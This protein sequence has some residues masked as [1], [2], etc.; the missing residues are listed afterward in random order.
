MVADEID[1]RDQLGQ[2][3]ERV[4]LALDRDQH[5]V[6]GRQRVDGEQASDGG[7]VD[8]DR[9]RIDRAIGSQQL[10]EATVSC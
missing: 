8:E 4:V 3:L 2:A 10:A 1:R 7:T 9:S 6:G 5:R